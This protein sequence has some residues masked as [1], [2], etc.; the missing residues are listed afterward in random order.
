[1]NKAIRAEVCL[2]HA[3]GDV[4]HYSQL[5][6]DCVQLARDETFL[7]KKI[8]EYIRDLPEDI[9]KQ[10]DFRYLRGNKVKDNKFIPYRFIMRRKLNELIYNRFKTEMNKY[11]QDAKTI[12]R[13]NLDMDVYSMFIKCQ[14]HRNK[15]ISISNKVVD[16]SKHKLEQ[17][18]KNLKK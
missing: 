14:K 13:I 16:H 7:I 17:V 18:R 3:L 10:Y 6:G 11:I 1:M 2:A 4:T 5:V 9:H 15:I 12:L 8:R